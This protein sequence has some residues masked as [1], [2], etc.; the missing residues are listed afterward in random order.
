M[1][2]QQN[3]NTSLDIDIATNV[4]AIM[5]II[6]AINSVSIVARV[7]LLRL[8][9]ETATELICVSVSDNKEPTTH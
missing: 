1:S 5:S 7:V 9:W 2:F 4:S 3:V 6:T 8:K